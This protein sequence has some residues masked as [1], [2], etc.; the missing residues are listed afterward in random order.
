MLQNHFRIMYDVWC[1]AGV[2]VV[3][4]CGCMQLF[5]CVCVCVCVHTDISQTGVDGSQLF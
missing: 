3:S 4:V 1:L 5:V 2:Y